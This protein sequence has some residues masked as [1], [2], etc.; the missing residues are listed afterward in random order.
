MS[1]LRPAAALTA[2]VVALGFGT[3]T[4]VP[5]S[6]VDATATIAQVQGTGASTPVAG[7]VVTVEGV[8]TADFTAPTGSGYRGLFLQDPNA[9]TVAGASDGIFVF[10]GNHDHRRRH[11]RPRQR[12]RHR[13]RV[14]RPHPD[15]RIAGTAGIEVLTPGVGL[16]RPPAARHRR[17]RGP[18]AVRGHARR[19]PRAPTSSSTHEVDRFGTLWLAGRACRSRAPRR[20]DAGEAADA[21]AAA[22][23]ARTLLLD[24]GKNNQVTN[25][26]T[27][28]QP[29][30]ETATA[31]ATATV[32]RPVRRHG[33]HY[34]FDDWRLQPQRPMTRPPRPR[35]RVRAR[36][37]RQPAHGCAGRRRRRPHGRARSTSSTT[38]RPSPR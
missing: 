32:R 9:G 38:S 37:E 8:I 29:Y 17:R 18:G 35:R 13:R 16:R 14:L 20:R 24:D 27:R 11:R 1:R 21:I 34:G 5:A 36:R 31:C 30:F 22:N 23:D 7:S 4:A 10:L 19:P 12:H 2:L 33:A 6:A 28:R 15:Q 26:A 25:A 3:L